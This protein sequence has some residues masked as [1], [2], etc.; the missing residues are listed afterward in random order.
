[1]KLDQLGTHRRAKLG[2]EVRERLV[3]QE[4]RGIA[5]D[6]AA[7]RDT[8]LLPAGERLGLARQHLGD[9]EGLG[10][11]LNAPVDLVP[12]RL[13]QL[14]R[15]AEILCDRHVGIERVGLEDHRDVPVL[16]VDPRDVVLADDDLAGR[17]LLQP[18]DHPKRR[19][20]AAARRADQHHQFAAVDGEV[21]G[22]DGDGLA[23]L[24][25]Q[26][27]EPDIGHAKTPM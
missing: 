1:M 18:G 5:H 15:E 24:L 23:E 4:D 3:E 26:I 11:L 20:L 8:L 10:H 7:Q 25:G 19:G 13:A 6:G 27:L 21:D 9:A 22:V 12:R 14:E 2:I 16:R 17:D